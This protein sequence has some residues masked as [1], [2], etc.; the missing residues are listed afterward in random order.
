MKKILNKKIAYRNDWISIVKKKIK[1]QYKGTNDYYSLNQK[2]YV[3]ILVQTPNKLFPMVKQYRHAINKF[4]LEFPSGLLEKK[5]TPKQC[6]RKEVLEETGH[7]IETLKKISTSYPDSGRLSN[8]VHMFFAKSKKQ[9]IEKI[10]KKEEIK[11]KYYSKEQIKKLIKDN[12]ILHQ[13]HIGLFYS[14]IIHKLI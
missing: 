10:N 5:E 1:F 9:K 4:T 8:R 3:Y 7:K 6:A 11:V 12:K 2:D 14:A 13:P